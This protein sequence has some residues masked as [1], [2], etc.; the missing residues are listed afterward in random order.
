MCIL[1]V[2]KSPV[3]ASMFSRA[4]NAA[5]F[6]GIFVEDAA[7]ALEMLREHRFEVV[8]TRPDPALESRLEAMGQ[9]VLRTSAQPNR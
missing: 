8:M 1:V 5:G 6:P 2:E 7:S 9:T 3:I 4:L